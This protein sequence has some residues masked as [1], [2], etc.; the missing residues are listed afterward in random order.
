MT[1]ARRVDVLSMVLHHGAM[2][3]RR[4]SA[5][6]GAHP[7]SGRE[8]SLS[9]AR[10]PPRGLGIVDLVATGYGSLCPLH[11]VESP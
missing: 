8:V 9:P 2:F 7:S 4:G 3:A 1:A 5:P 6:K 10:V 11:L